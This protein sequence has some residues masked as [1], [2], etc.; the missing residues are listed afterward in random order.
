[1]IRYEAERRS[2]KPRL[3]VCGETSSNAAL[4]GGCIDTDKDEISFLDSHVD[5][6]REEKVAATSLTNDGF[7]TGFVNWQLVVWAIP[8]VYAGL[9]QIYNGNLD[10][11]AFESN[12][13]TGG[14]T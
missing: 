11:G 8:C 5:V 4:L 10:V 6:R 12:D 14:A 3:Q 13:C 2:T 9:V 7:K 1:M